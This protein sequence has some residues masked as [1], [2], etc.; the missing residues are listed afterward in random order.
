MAENRF[1]TSTRRAWWWWA[2]FYNNLEQKNTY[3]NHDVYTD[4]VWEFLIIYRL[5][6]PEWKRY[7]IRKNRR[8]LPMRYN[9][10]VIVSLMI[11]RWFYSYNH[12]EK[13][14]TNRDL[15]LIWGLAF[16]PDL[17]FVKTYEE[18]PN[19]KLEK[20]L[21]S[22][23]KL[24]FSTTERKHYDPLDKNSF[25]KYTKYISKTFFRESL[26]KVLLNL[27]DE[28]EGIWWILKRYHIWDKD[29][30]KHLFFLVD[31]FKAFVNSLWL[32]NK[33][34]AKNKLSERRQLRRKTDF[35][36]IVS[37]LDN[38]S[39]EET[40]PELEWMIAAV[41]ENYENATEEDEKEYLKKSL[42]ELECLSPDDLYDD[43]T[44]W[45]VRT[46]LKG[47]SLRCINKFLPWETNLNY[48][49][50]QK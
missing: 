11:L 42:D 4:L 39:R 45:D 43:I 36:I 29:I 21:P 10:G 8:F 47:Y 20:P 15:V 17:Q 18:L 27:Q 5:I 33:F 6:H 3:E 50:L 25:Q 35:E 48:H 38:I 13:R 32:G 23:Y 44:L 9:P 12:P 2:I 40:I 41:K 28:N 30:D 49:Y 1:T 26:D 16:D 37:T 24:Y 19:F 46:Y 31:W 22:S 7:R 34:L 14:L